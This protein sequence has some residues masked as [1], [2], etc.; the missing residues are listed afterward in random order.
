MPSLSSL[1]VEIETVPTQSAHRYRIRYYR[2]DIEG[3]SRTLVRVEEV[4]DSVQL[5]EKKLSLL[6]ASIHL[7]Y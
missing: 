7:S 3:L 5:N 6:R 4:G 1:E 2:P